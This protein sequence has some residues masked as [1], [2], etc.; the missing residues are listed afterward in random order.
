MRLAVSGRQGVDWVELDEI[1]R[2]ESDNNYTTIYLRN[3]QRMVMSRT[4]K[5]LERELQEPK[6]IRVHRSHLVNIGFVKSL[7]S[8]EE[9]VIHLDNG[10]VVPVSRRRRADV[11]KAMEGLTG[12]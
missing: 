7:N 3:G 11:L 9:V 1:I 4:L 8:R 6:F 10:A 2:C 12:G 5:S